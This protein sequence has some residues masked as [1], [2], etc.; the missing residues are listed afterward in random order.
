MKKIDEYLEKQ[1]EILKHEKEEYLLDREIFNK[2]TSKEKKEGYLYFDT[3]NQVYYKV[4]PLE[5]SDQDILKIQNLETEIIRLKPSSG[6]AGFFRILSIFLF[7]LGIL[8]S[9]ILGITNS[10]F[11]FLATIFLFV[12]FSFLFL[13]ISRIIQLLEEIR[14][15]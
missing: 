5:V 14:R 7:I 8:V 10:F 9:V 2:V 13:G 4:E 6:Y 12:M 3:L 15:K 11:T 1:K